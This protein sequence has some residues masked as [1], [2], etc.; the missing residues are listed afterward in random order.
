MREPIQASWLRGITIVLT[1]MLTVTFFA[2]SQEQT[3]GEQPP[4]GQQSVSAER[5]REAALPTASH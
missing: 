2:Q 4:L 5:S 3:S 1:L